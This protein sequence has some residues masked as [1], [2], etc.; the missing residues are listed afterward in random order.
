MRPGVGVRRGITTAGTAALILICAVG[1]LALLVWLILRRPPASRIQRALE[2][3]GSRLEEID[4][5][6]QARPE[7][8]G[9][10]PAI[11]ETLDLGEVLQRTLASTPALGVGRV[12]GARVTIRRPDGR[13]ETATSGL[14]RD[15]AEAVLGPPP[16]GSAYVSTLASWDAPAGAIRSG[17]AVPLAGGSLSVYSCTEGAFDAAS[18]RL[19]AEIARNAEPAVRNALAHQRVLDEA[20]TD[21]LTGLGSA[22]SFR[23][24]LP[25]EIEAGRRHE[26]PLCLLQIDL[27]DF[28]AVNKTFGQH[29]G[30]AVLAEFALRLRRTI[31]GSDLGYRN[32]GGADEFFV[33]LPD[34]ARLDAQN[35]YRR[36][37]FE[38]AAEPFPDVGKVTMSCGLVQL[39][40]DET[41]RDLLQRADELVRRSKRD[42]K[43]RLSDDRGSAGRD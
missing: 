31:R 15:D 14:V 35:L 9:L 29:A 2:E 36:L 7:P 25:R 18:A 17:L 30:D 22:R 10:G 1:V 11:V 8:P 33:L 6:V 16:D 41:A 4:S 40:P 3:I 13:I 27:D 23:E 26:R 32:S 19:L 5:K 28:G 34:T 39:R 42:G 20:A 37:A 12:D 38:M 24:A 21:P 43:N